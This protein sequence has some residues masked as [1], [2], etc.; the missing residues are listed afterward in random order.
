MTSDWSGWPSSQAGVD[1]SAVNRCWT[2]L[3]AKLISPTGGGDT[4]AGTGRGRGPPDESVARSGTYA[5]S[6]LSTQAE[7]RLGRSAPVGE[8]GSPVTVV[9]LPGRRAGLDVVE[10]LLTNISWTACPVLV[11]LDERSLRP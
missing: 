10:E 5:P 9:S 8:A 11:M 4:R 7:A 3:Q 1:T 6:S 2:S